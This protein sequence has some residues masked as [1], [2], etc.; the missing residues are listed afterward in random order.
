MKYWSQFLYPC[1]LESLVMTD[2]GLHLQGRLCLG[3]VETAMSA[4]D[5][6]TVC[7]SLFVKLQ[8]K[9]HIITEHC[10]IFFFKHKHLQM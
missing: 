4:C 5:H 6:R 2:D 8:F 1:P 10:K 9:F 7:R 3:R